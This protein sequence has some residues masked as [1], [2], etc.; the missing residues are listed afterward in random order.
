[1]QRKS[2]TGSNMGTIMREVKNGSERGGKENSVK[3]E[4]EQK[5]ERTSHIT[6]AEIYAL[7]P[8][9]IHGYGEGGGFE[10]SVQNKN[11]ADIKTFYEVT[12]NYLAKFFKNWEETC[13]PP[14]ILHYHYEFAPVPN[15]NLSNQNKTNVLLFYS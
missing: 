15:H 3:S 13:P 8:G 12:Q 4:I 11:D 6:S 9:M 14:P 2:G 5:D 10:F 1:M 7:A